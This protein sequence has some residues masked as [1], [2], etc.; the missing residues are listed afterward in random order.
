MMRAVALRE[1]GGYREDVIASEDDE[2]G[3]RLRAA[4]WRIWK[5]EDEMAFHDADILRFR[6]WW[7][8]TV[9]GGYGFAHGAYLHGAPPERHW[10]RETRRA[11]AWGL[12]APMACF[13]AT[14]LFWPHGLATFLVY[15]AQVVRLSV[16]NGGAL[17]D[18]TTLALFQTLSRFPEVWGQMKF[19]L[20]RLLKQPSRLIEYK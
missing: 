15:P 9:R 14:L 10:V 20:D 19:T 8:R 11:W 17:R 4:G 6:Q 18:R 2:L 16:R 1:V 12:L 3:V 13:A 5:L 7:K